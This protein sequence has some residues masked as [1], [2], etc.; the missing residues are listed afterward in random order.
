LVE[1]V[2]FAD[3]EKC[4]GC[5]IC[6]MACT[7]EQDGFFAPYNSRISIVKEEKQGINIPIVC[8]QCTD[9]PCA[10]VCPL[11]LYDR[12]PETGALE[13]RDEA[14]I[15]CKAC[16]LACPYGANLSHV[17]S[18][19]SIKCDLCGGDPTC[20]EFCPT[21]ALQYVRVDEVD[22]LLKRSMFNK[23]SN[24]LKEMRKIK[25]GEK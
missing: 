18:K 25:R 21:D 3:P 17:E 11:N 1:K 12:N 5:R 10:E 14:C 7:L 2:I 4:T 15:G 8:Q 9:A 23:M 19:V 16:I 22:K 13:I 24:A 6:E 20:V